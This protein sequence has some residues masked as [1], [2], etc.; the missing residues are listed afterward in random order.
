MFTYSA[1]SLTKTSSFCCLFF[2]VLKKTKNNKLIIGKWS[3]MHI[4]SL[5]QNDHFM[6]Y[7][8]MNILMVCNPFSHLKAWVPCF[9]LQEKTIHPFTQCLYIFLLLNRIS[10]A[11]IF[12]ISSFMCLTHQMPWVLANS[13][14]KYCHSFRFFSSTSSV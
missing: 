1:V 10:S 9:N 7:Q 13:I 2:Q 3:V 11:K 8:S 14:I 6:P 5:L 12:E 4:K